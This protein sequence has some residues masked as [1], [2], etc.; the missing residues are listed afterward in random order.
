MDRV[1]DQKLKLTTDGRTAVALI[2]RG[3]NRLIIFAPYGRI[4][5]R[6]LGQGLA[7]ILNVLDRHAAVYFHFRLAHALIIVDLVLLPVQ[8]SP[9]KIQNVPDVLANAAVERRQVIILV[10][11]IAEFI[12]QSLGLLEEFNVYADKWIHGK[13]A[14]LPYSG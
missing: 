4:N 10:L 14:L 6:L 1:I 12:D 2:G 3:L 11:V 7:N 5:G 8:K 13:T 9:V